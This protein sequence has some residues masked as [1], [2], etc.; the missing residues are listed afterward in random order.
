MGVVI[1]C[2]DTQ[3]K[4]PV[5]LKTFKPEFLNKRATRLRF[6][7]EAADWIFLGSHPNIVTA[8]RVEQMGNPPQPYIVMEPIQ[9]ARDDGLVAL[10]DYIRHPDASPFSCQRALQTALEITRGMQYAVSRIEGLVHRDLK[11]GNILIDKNGVARVC[12]FGLLWTLTEEASLQRLKFL[13]NVR[14]DEYI[15]AGS[16]AYIAPEAWER[17]NVIDCRADIYAVGLILLEM[18]TGKQAVPP[19]DKEVARKIHRNGELPELDSGVPEVIH[20]LVDK[21][22][23]VD[24]NDR[25]TD[26]AALESAISFAYEKVTGAAPQALPENEAVIDRKSNA[27]SYISI[28][29]SFLDLGYAEVAGPYLVPALQ[30]A[31]EI[32]DLPLEMQARLSLARVRAYEHNLEE[33]IEIVKLGLSRIDDSVDTRTQIEFQ[34]LLGNLYA[35][36]G[37]F[38][39]AINGLNASLTQAQSDK[40][41]DAQILLL[42]SIANTYAEQKSFARAIMYFRSQLERLRMREDPLNTVTCLANLGTAYL[43]AGQ[44]LAAVEYLTEASGR[45]EQIGDLVGCGQTLKLLC[46][47]HRGLDDRASL[48]RSATRYLKL[49]RQFNDAEEANWAQIVMQEANCTHPDSD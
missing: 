32:S 28:G 21:C 18:L 36:D 19:Q 9:S 24:K 47:V 3:D 1:F 15:P 2:D 14:D 46:E 40:N 26:W 38:E 13:R 42:G 17:L 12:D 6:L 27:R 30:L 41:D 5:A 39:Q 4:R 45:A 7:E 20:R 34:A 22:T 35:R 23:A 43:D 10:S 33:A 8:Y 29:A 48:C 25:Y 16:T 37:N 49:C 31:Q 44:P 11:P